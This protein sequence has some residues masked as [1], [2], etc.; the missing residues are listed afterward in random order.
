LN[1]ATATLRWVEADQRFGKAPAS[2]A[3]S[4]WRI[5]STGPYTWGLRAPRSRVTLANNVSN[6]YG[7]FISLTIV[8]GSRLGKSTGE[9]T[10]SAKQSEVQGPLGPIVERRCVGLRET[11][12]TVR[13]RG[14]PRPGPVAMERRAATESRT[15]KLAADSHSVTVDRVVHAHSRIASALPRSA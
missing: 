4:D 15:S 1:T 7:G 10:C 5:A 8:F 3:T 2:A 13:A 9:L 12:E 11:D 6:S 14:R